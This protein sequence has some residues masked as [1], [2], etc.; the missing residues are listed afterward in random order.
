MVV[1]GVVEL[2]G[3]ADLRR[4]RPV[5]GGV[6][7][8]LVGVA[9]GLGLRLLLLAVGVDRRAVLRADVVAL[10]HALRRVVALPE[11]AQQL[12]VGHL[13]RVEHHAHTSV[14]PVRPEQ[15]SS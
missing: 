8:L 6:E 12:L 5:A 14:W 15:T 2:G 4:D 13:L 9:R 11:D 7:R 10:A 3:L 1:L